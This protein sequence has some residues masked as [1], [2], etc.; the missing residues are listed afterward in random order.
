MTPDNFAKLVRGGDGTLRVANVLLHAEG[1][2]VRGY[3]LL[4]ITPAVLALHFEVS[5]KS[6]MPKRRKNI[7]KEDDFWSLSGIIARD[8][9]F[10]C[11][12]VSPGQ[13]TDHWK[14]GN[15]LQTVQVL[16]LSGIELRSA[17]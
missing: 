4:K 14:L 7:W 12:R 17:A 13:R 11:N 15:A 6:V 1:C 16:H 8:L 2:K 10:S 5:S 9:H 3:G